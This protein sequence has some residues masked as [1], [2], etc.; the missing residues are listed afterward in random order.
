M[1]QPADSAR[2]GENCKIPLQI[3]CQLAASGTWMHVT[4]CCIL[5][6]STLCC[7][8]RDHIGPQSGSHITTQAALDYQAVPCTENQKRTQF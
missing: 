6:A 3:R 2:L 8:E 5:S 1:E 4:A 7:R